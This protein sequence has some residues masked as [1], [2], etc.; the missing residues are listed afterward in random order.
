MALK[1]RAKQIFIDVP[2][3]GEALEA[4]G[5]GDG[6]KLGAHGDAE[7]AEPRGPV[8]VLPEPKAP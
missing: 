7:R 8:Q 5:L 3:H 2:L 1:R 6:V 4:S